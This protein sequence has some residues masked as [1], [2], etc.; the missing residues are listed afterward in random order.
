MLNKFSC[1]GHI[2]VIS[3]R[4]TPSGVEICDMRLA[5]NE[6]YK[7]KEGEKVEKTEWVSVQVFGKQA[8]TCNKYLSKGRLVYVEGN[9]RTR[10]YEKDGEN[11]YYTYVQGKVVQFLD[12]KRN[13]EPS[14]ISEE[15]QE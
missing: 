15:E 12:R 6:Y 5:L 9:L 7:N 2:G 1:I 11:R 4:F 10:Q 13:D 14:S 3:Q 8:A